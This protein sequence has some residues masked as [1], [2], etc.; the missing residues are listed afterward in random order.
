MAGG[1]GNPGLGRGLPLSLRPGRRRSPTAYP[2]SVP[3]GRRVFLA[4]FA[5]ALGPLSFGFALGYSSPAIPSLRRAAP[6]APR[7]SDD[8]ASWFGVRPPP[9]TPHAHPGDARGAPPPAWLGADAETLRRFRPGS[10]ARGRPLPDH[11]P[12]TR[13]PSR[14]GRW[15][16]VEGEVGPR[17][18]APPPQLAAARRPS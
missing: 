10:P 16:W 11:Q 6:P 1:R 14:G 2:R 9:G 17:P 8:A 7:L 4:A 12:G 3:R 13:S 18:P 15:G 5:A